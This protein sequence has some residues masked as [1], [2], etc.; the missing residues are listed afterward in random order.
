MAYDQDAVDAT[1]ALLQPR[2][3]EILRRLD[4]LEAQPSGSA[5]FAARDNFETAVFSAMQG[6][7]DAEQVKFL[8]SLTAQIKGN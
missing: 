1:V 7:T 6:M 2:F 3:D 5:L 8:N 4:A